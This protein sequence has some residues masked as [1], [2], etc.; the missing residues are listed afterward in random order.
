MGSDH[1]NL[2]SRP[3]HHVHSEKK[4]EEDLLNFDPGPHQQ[5]NIIFNHALYF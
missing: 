1:S 4:V 5:G 3:S 2:R